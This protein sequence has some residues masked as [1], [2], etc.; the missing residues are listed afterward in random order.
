MQA[1]D[2]GV[3]QG[4][5]NNSLGYP[6]RPGAGECQFF[7]RTQSCKYGVSC[8]FTHPEPL[9]MATVAA[10]PL[11]GYVAMHSGPAEG[12]NARGFPIRTGVAVCS[13][14]QKTGDCKF[15]ATCKWDH[16]EGLDGGMMGMGITNSLGN[17]IRPGQTPCNFFMRTGTCSFAA[18]CKFDHPE[19]Y[20]ALAAGGGQP[21]ARP[22]PAPIAAATGYNSLGYPVRTGS[23]P[24]T[25]YLKTGSCTFGETCKWDHPEGAGGSQPKG[26]GKGSVAGQNPFFRASPY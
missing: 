19:E 8:Q 7:L 3:M 15:G 1:F 11:S 21:A 23:L 18:T 12:F 14:F 25:F 20:T 26:A 17:P 10:N 9:G 13:F 5:M 16:T 24:C 6:I 2:L 22:P 4:G